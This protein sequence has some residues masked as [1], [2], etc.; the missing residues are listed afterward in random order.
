MKTYALIVDGL[1]AEIIP[2]YVN[3][4]GVEVPIEER[5]TPNMVLMM[6]DITG[7]DPWPEPGW[8][9]DGTVFAA[10]VPVVPDNNQLAYNARQ[11]RD[12]LFRTVAD[13]GT[14]MAQRAIRMATNP[15][16]L[17][18]A[19]DKLAEIDAYA[20]ALQG[21]PEQAGFPLTIEWPTAPTK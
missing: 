3:P 19:Q 14:L 1:V 7:L 21:V 13:P 15:D 2:P 16:D 6:V 12:L 18:Y 10:P 8:T 5:Y 4:D 9:Y 17:A 20:V 11:Q